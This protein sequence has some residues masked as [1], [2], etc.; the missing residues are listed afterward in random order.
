MKIKVSY[1]VFGNWSTDKLYDSKKEGWDKLVFG[2]LSQQ[3]YDAKEMEWKE[4]KKVLFDELKN[5]TWD[6]PL[7]LDDIEIAR[8]FVLEE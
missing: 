5:E 7:T 1:T 8:V 6:F 2:N 3:I 4:I